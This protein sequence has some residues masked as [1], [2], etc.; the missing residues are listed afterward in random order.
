[1][2]TYRI[3]LYHF[4]INI[5]LIKVVFIVVTDLFNSISFGPSWATCKS[6][7]RAQPSAASAAISLTETDV[8]VHTDLS[9]S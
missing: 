6:N 1:M 4:V 2:Y 9:Y 8:Y 3:L 5:Y 7:S